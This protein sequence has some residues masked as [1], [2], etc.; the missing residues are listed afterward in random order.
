M[1]Q[2]P[3]RSTSSPSG[4]PVQRHLTDRVW[5]DVPY[6]DKD[7]A[8]QLGARWDADQKRWYDPRPPT[9]GL[10]RW[11]GLPDVPEELAGEDRMFG[12]GL[13]VD[14]VPASCW[15]TNVR[16]CVNERD[17][18]RLR[19]PIIRRAGQA[20]EVCRRGEDR[21]AGRRLEVHERW[22]YDQASTT[23]TLRRLICL[24]SDCHTTTH[25]GLANIRGRATEALAHL[26]EVT[27]MDDH[28]VARHVEAANQLWLERSQRDW[29]LDL[30][31]LT[32]AGITVARPASPAQRRHEAGTRLNATATAAVPDSP[33]SPRGP[34]DGAG[35]PA[36]LSEPIGPAAQK[37]AE[38]PPTRAQLVAETRRL[39][40]GTRWFGD[41][42]RG[43]R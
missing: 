32:D 41:L 22:H 35:Q 16:S 26:R 13:F 18:E 21:A 31:M 40:R 33:R 42:L 20:C 12:A 24:C 29:T 37:P 1:H 34:V 43:P 36:W 11:V 23:Q 2:Q 9:A 17:W 5:L 8:K 30:S 25:L 10:E 38:L 39:R 28:Q 27:G 7:A 3:P 4:L 19:R 6:S 15:F 14:M